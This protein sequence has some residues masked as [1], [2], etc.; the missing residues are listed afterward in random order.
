M[1]PSAR[2]DR[3]VEVG[4]MR[5]VEETAPAGPDADSEFDPVPGGPMD[6]ELAPLDG[7]LARAGE[8][9]RSANRSRTEPTRFFSSCERWM[10]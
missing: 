1:L 6:A 10:T 2:R 4:R 8:R 3:W 5:P 9:A 7:E